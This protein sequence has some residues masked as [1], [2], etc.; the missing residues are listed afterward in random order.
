MIS[1]NHATIHPLI[2]QSL[3]SILPVMGLKEWKILSYSG[4]GKCPPEA[5]GR[6]RSCAVD[7]AR[8]RGRAERAGRSERRL[9]ACFGSGNPPQATAAL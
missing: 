1:K 8:F 3:I 2:Y 7:K 4:E 5:P 9:S 6:S